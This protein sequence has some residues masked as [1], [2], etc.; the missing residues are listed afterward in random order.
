M[1]SDSDGEDPPPTEE[2]IMITKAL[3]R[4]ALR[5]NIPNLK[6]LLD[7]GAD[8]EATNAL[9]YK[10]YDLV[11]QKDK[12]KTVDFFTS[13][14]IYEKYHPEKYLTGSAIL[15]KLTKKDPQLDERLQSRPSRD[16]G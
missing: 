13:I 15:E 3:F 10:V 6:A 2:Q 14:G 12:H 5:E 1:A 8:I 16:R 11:M 4:A 7:A 9:G